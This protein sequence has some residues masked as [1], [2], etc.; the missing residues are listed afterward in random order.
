MALIRYM[1]RHNHALA[2]DG[3]EFFFCPFYCRWL[4]EQ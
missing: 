4:D 1:A 2:F 3:N